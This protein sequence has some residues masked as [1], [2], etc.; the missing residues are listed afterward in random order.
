MLATFSVCRKDSRLLIDLLNWIEVLGPCKD[1]IALIV[2][3]AAT[4]FNDVLEARTIAD[5]VFKGCEVITN[6]VS[7]DGWVEGPKSLFLNAAQWAQ[8]AGMPFL[9]LETDSIPL[10]PGW[11]DAIDAEY[12]ACGKPYMGHIYAKECD[13]PKIPPLMMSGIGV[14]PATAYQ[15]LKAVITAG[16]NWDMAM[17][18]AMIMQAANTNLIHHFWGEFNNPPV[19]GDERIERSFQFDCNHFKS[20]AVLFHRSKDHS[21]IR[22]LLRR[23]YP[24]TISTLPITV[25]LPVAHDIGLAILHARWMRQ[26][27]CKHAHKTVIAFDGSINLP[28]LNEFKMLVEPM[29]ASVEMFTYPTPPVKAW[30]QAPNWAWQHVANHMSFQD[31]PWLWLEADAVVLK[32]DWLEQLQA[33]YEKAKHLFMGPKVKG[34]SHANGCMVYPADASIRMPKA[35]AATNHAWDYVCSSEMMHDCHDSSHLM[36]HW[37]S[38]MGDEISQVGGGQVPQNITLD[39]AKRWLTKEAVFVHRVKDASLVSMLIQ[40]VLKPDLWQAK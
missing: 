28:M 13:D 30:P 11:L 6:D 18:P 16:E 9:V 25:V 33:E 24:A 20:G 7:V 26:M 27:G 37:W 17:T 10:K 2:A 1:H 4:P 29:F 22:C 40:G 31:R 19:F 21:L 38:V 12:K 36:N 39:Q 34:M 3:D 35:M 8:N 14:Y 23:D 5:R 15:E 32:P